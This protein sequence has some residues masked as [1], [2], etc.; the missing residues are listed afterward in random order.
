MILIAT[1][2]PAVERQA[3]RMREDY[4]AEPLSDCALQYYYYVPCP[5]YSWFWA[6]YDW[7]RGDIVGEWFSIGDLGTGGW[8]ACSPFD[9][10]VLE[11]IRVIDFAGYGQV[12]PGMFTV[13]FDVYCADEY[14]CPMGPSLWNSGPFEPE[15]AWNYIPVE[16]PLT[17]CGCSV[18]PGP[19]PSSPRLLV[20][21]KHIG[22]EGYYPAWGT[23]NI[24]TPVELGCDMH[25][26]GCLPALYPRP[27]ASHYGSI[28]SGYYGNWGFDYCPP[29]RFLD[30][31]D[32]TPDGTQYGFVEL[33]W[34]IYVTCTGPSATEAATWGAIKG[35]YR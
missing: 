20:T 12:H 21:A 9:C 2:V 7:Q 10:H 6:H 34:R 15:F 17:I 32:T 14:G 3:Y 30:K 35:M 33:A 19:P 26:L 24:S 22:Y 4:D 13:E 28:H 31:Y 5:T 16:P 29:R 1:T 23:D 18:S 25:D 8:D 11:R 27:H